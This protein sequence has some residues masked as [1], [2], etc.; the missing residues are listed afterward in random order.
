MRQP[1]DLRRPWRAPARDAQAASKMTIRTAFGRC[2]ADEL[3]SARLAGVEQLAGQATRLGRF[4]ER[5]VDTTPRGPISQVPRRRDQ[6][7]RI[8]RQH[9]VGVLPAHRR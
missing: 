2:A 1:A 5:S 7:G 4:E 9:E 3:D 6:R 8:G